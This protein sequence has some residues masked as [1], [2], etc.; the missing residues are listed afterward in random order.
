MGLFSKKSNKVADEKNDEKPIETYKVTYRGGHPDYAKAKV[1]ALLLDMFPD[2]FELRPTNAVKWFSPLTLPYD[3]ITDLKIVERQVG[4]AEGIL[5]GLN[6]R[7][8]NQA[9]NIHISYSYDG[10]PIVLRLEMLTG[11]TVMGQAKKCREFEDRLTTHRIREK[12]ATA[13]APQTPASN[14]SE[15]SASTDSAHEIK[16]YAI[17][18][19][20]GILTDEEFQAKKKQLLDL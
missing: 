17:L 15:R 6:S 20:R 19:Q 4:T 7:Q 3:K 14:A 16:K 10:Q 11:V 18:H 1:N 8:L 9:N 13:R 12:F 2:R 5:G